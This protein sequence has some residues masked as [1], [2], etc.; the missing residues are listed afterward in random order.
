MVDRRLLLSRLK[1]GREV[2][3]LVRSVDGRESKARAMRG[4]LGSRK[5]VSV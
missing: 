1:L 4:L 5:A 2:A 3:T